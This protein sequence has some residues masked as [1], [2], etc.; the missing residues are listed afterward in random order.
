MAL[1]SHHKYEG[2]TIIYHKLKQATINFIRVG[3]GH[4]FLSPHCVTDEMVCCHFHEIPIPL[5][6]IRIRSTSLLLIHDLA[7]NAS[8][9][10]LWDT[11]V[12][13][14]SF[15][16]SIPGH[17]LPYSFNIAYPSLGQKHLL[18]WPFLKLKSL[19][20]L[21]FL[22]VFKKM[23]WDIASCTQARPVLFCALTWVLMELLIPNWWVL[24]KG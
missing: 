20:I 1:K 17:V 23:S 11:A 3:Q 14:G 24:C 7:Q 21:N 16:I 4:L 18:W 13:C 8:G 19:L 9:F 22:S 15:S 12:S 5:F 6:H 2:A 10:F